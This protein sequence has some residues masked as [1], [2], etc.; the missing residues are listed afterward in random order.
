MEYPR[1][2]TS[3]QIAMQRSLNEMVKLV[4]LLIHMSIVWRQGESWNRGSR[5]GRLR[6]GDGKIQQITDA[7]EQIVGSSGLWKL[8]ACRGTGNAEGSRFGMTVV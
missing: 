7:A 2:V 5:R 6:P 1:S 4:Q 8:V 3:T